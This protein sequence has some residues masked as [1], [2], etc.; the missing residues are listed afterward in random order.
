MEMKYAARVRLVSVL[1]TASVS[2]ATGQGDVSSA[3]AQEHA[4]SPA[5]RCLQR[6]VAATDL[7]DVQRVQLCT[8]ATGAEPVACFVQATET[9]LLADEQGI[10]LCRCATSLAPIECA[11]RL[12]AD[13]RYTDPEIV[14]MC[15][16]AI[17]CGTVR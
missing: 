5:A 6:A 2:V 12:R 13:V 14:V 3:S 8:G 4:L 17:A 9:L 7:L 11:R 16:A 15:G 1:L 10:A